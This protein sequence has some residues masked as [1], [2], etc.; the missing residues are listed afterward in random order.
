MPQHS[1][2]P[3]EPRTWDEPSNGPDPRQLALPFDRPIS[4][5]PWPETTTKPDVSP[6]ETDLKSGV[7]SVHRP[8][9]LRTAQRHRWDG[10]RCRA[11]GLVR[12]GQNGRFFGHSRFITSD[13]E[14]MKVPGD[15][16]GNPRP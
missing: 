13:G 14:V 4:A 15:C 9:R 6:R 8:K 11:C 7:G 10:H 3:T 12:E 1:T 5:T 2:R 16:P